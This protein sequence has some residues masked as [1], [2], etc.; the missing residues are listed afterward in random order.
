MSRHPTSFRSR[1][2]GDAWFS[3]SFCGRIFGFGCS[4]FRRF[5]SFRSRLSGG[6]WLSPGFCGRF[7]RFCYVSFPCFGHG[8]NR[9]RQFQLGRFRS[10]MVA[11][12]QRLDVSS[13]FFRPQLSVCAVSAFV[14]KVFW[15]RFSCHSLSVAELSM[16]ELSNF[17]HSVRIREPPRGSWTETYYAAAIDISPG[18]W[19]RFP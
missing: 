17:A 5:G 1:L 2:S 6:A 12:M 11:M 18:S 9:S 16:P 3:P 8:F 15:N 13:F 14:L 7:S 10:A 19:L 4:R